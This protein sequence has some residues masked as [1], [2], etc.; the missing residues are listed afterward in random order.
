MRTRV[1]YQFVLVL[2]LFLNSCNSN[3]N[4]ELTSQDINTIKNEIKMYEEIIRTNELE[5][6]E[7]IFTDDIVFIRPDNDNIF[8]IDSL[9]KIHYSGVPAISGFWK[10]ADEIHGHG[11]VAYTFGNFGFSEGVPAGKYIE[12]RIKQSDGSWPI[13]RLIWNENSQK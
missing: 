2:T 1:F 11:D 13:S 6:L 10:S 8:G 7:S 12:I 4:E 5:K 9:L 3:H